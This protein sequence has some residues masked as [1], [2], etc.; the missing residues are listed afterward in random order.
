MQTS[1]VFATIHDAIPTFPHRTEVHE[2][3]IATREA[4]KQ[5]HPKKIGKKGGGNSH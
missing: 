5:V 2:L 1:E 3:D 4:L